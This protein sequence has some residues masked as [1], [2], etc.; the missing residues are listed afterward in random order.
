MAR[1]IVHNPDGSISTELTETVTD[2]RLNQGYPTNIPRLY[3]G[4]LVSLTNALL[5]VLRAKGKDSE[6]GR[7]LPTFMT[8]PEAVSA[9]K[10]RS[11]LLG[12][13]YGQ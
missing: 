9:A 4:R 7:Q 6:T 3:N 12:K 2:P 10:Q 8:I 11:Q 1:K 5:R 13:Q